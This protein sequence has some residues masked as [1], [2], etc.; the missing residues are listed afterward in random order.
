MEEHY[1]AVIMAGGG[2]TR[3]RGDRVDAK[4]ARSVLEIEQAGA[5]CS[6]EHQH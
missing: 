2:G 3:L 4:R 6:M 1:F 5:P